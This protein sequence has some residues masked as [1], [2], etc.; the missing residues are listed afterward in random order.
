MSIK[1][2]TKKIV[3]CF[4]VFAFA[5]ALS[6]P[7]FSAQVIPSLF[8]PAFCAARRSGMATTRASRFAAELSVDILR[9]EAPSIDGVPLDVK[10]AVQEAFSLCP[11]VFGV[12]PR[13][14]DY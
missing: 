12:A 8:A 5:G 11:E 2:K 1:T 4:F 6:A 14:V 13:V 7:A 9:P 3:S 10:L